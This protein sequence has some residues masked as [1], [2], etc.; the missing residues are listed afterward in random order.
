M[1][2]ERETGDSQR[3]LYNGGRHRKHVG[4]KVVVTEGGQEGKKGGGG[5][6]PEGCAAGPLARGEGE[7]A[8]FE[9][10]R[11]RSRDAFDIVFYDGGGCGGGSR[12][13][14]RGRREWGGR[15]GA[16]R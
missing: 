8:V 10:V 6:G 5:E 16:R 14:S 15:R 2:C 9:Y 13:R 1:L 12:R 3:L 7:G 4:S 11:G